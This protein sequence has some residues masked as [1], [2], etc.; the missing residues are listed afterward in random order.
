[1]D[2][3]EDVVEHNHAYVHDGWSVNNSIV[4]EMRGYCT[5]C[6]KHAVLHVSECDD[7]GN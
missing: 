4:F 3:A 2:E 6:G 7:D 5:I 1:M